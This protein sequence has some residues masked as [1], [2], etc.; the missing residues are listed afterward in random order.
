MKFNT[1]F[2]VSHLYIRS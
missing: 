2:I 1:G